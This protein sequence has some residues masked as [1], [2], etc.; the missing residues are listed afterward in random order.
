MAM[1]KQKIRL[2]LK[3]YDHQLLDN[4]VKQI[5]MTVKRTGS[6]IVGPVPLP[7]RKKIFT[8]LRSPHID[9]KSREQFELTTHK[10][11]LDIVSPVEQTMDA[12]M[13][14]NI[15]AGVDVEIK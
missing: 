4:A 2:T 1:K 14:L 12:L 5:V 8:V 13:K 3:S 7:N 9:K 15:S 6:Q 10:R 11:I